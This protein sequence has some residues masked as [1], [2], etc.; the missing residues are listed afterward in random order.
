MIASS[1]QSLCGSNAA[2]CSTFRNGCRRDGPPDG[3]LRA[4]LTLR[5]RPTWSSVVLSLTTIRDLGSRSRRSCRRIRVGTVPVSIRRCS[6]RC[7]S[8]ACCRPGWCAPA[9]RS[10]SCV[11]IGRARQARTAYGAAPPP[12]S[13]IRPGTRRSVS[14]RHGRRWRHDRTYHRD[15]YRKGCCRPGVAGA[16][17]AHHPA[18][19]RDPTSPVPHRLRPRHHTHRS[20]HGGAGRGPRRAPGRSHPPAG[21][22]DRD[23]ATPGT[24][25]RRP[26]R[27][28]RRT[29]HRAADR[30][31]DSDPGQT[32]Q[33]RPQPG[34]ARAAP[35]S[36]S[37]RLGR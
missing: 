17:R 5:R 25:H 2:R 22:I 28:T 7:R 19:S 15:G 10:V 27:P 34:S 4:A 36:G 37:P 9:A 20:S 30:G 26:H 24:D 12:P 33:R 6:S 8:W 16:D 14:R 29:T 13:V 35:R 32:T 11:G 21:R 31:R 3:T 18:A 23:Q 1:M